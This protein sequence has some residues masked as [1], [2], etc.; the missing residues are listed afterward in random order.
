VSRV[1]LALAIAIASATGCAGPA[2]APGYLEAFDSGR[3]ARTA[4]RL[5]QAEEAFALAYRRAGRVKDRDEA[6]LLL[7]R[8]QE[9]RG[10]PGDAAA[11]YQRIVDA[12]PPGPRRVHASYALARL[13][14]AKQGEAVEDAMERELIARNPDD[15]LSVAALSRVVARRRERGAWDELLAVLDPLVGATRG[16]SLEQ[17]IDVERAKALEARGDLEAA[18][19]LYLATARRHPYPHGP[20]TDDA[21]FRASY[22]E[23][24]LGRPRLAIA[25][26]VEMLEPLE[27]SYSAASYVRPKFPAAQM[28][29]ALLLRDRLGDREGARRALLRLVDAF[30]DSTMRDDAL[31]I[32]ARMARESGDLDRACGDVA[33]LRRMQP[34]SRYVRC[35]HLLC[36]DEA[37]QPRPCA[38]YLVRELRGEAA[39]EPGDLVDDEASVR[40]GEGVGPTAP[41]PGGLP[42]GDDP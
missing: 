35:G 36:P 23:E 39:G 38:D 22:V 33:R 10:R 37:P 3:R 24:K 32:A 17:S 16:T 12:R 9:A 14:G 2:Y 40:E 27:A 41:F 31:W 11:T 4:G 21:L 13:A 29:I 20:R 5:E 30:P 15:G 7:A 28:R 25:H 34:D 19:A 8:T 1:V 42:D 6:L 18:L 26:L